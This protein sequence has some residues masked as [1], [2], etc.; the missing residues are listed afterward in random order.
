MM[1]NLELSHVTAMVAFS[2]SVGISR[3]NVLA[4][5]AF[6]IHVGKLTQGSANNVR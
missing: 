6:S 3:L 1:G 5:Y 4:N 2:V